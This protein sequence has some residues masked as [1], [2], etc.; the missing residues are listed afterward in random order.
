MEAALSF[1]YASYRLTTSSLDLLLSGD[2]SGLA[3]CATA[4]AVD[5]PVA[6]LLW[7]ARFLER[8]A[9]PFAVHC[10][11][12]T[13]RVLHALSALGASASALA[14]ANSR[15]KLCDGGAGSLRPCMP[16]SSSAARQQG[17]STLSTF[18]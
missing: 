14:C 12:A 18:S 5:S 15:G 7:S 3:I 9:P 11:N 2:G 10:N 1:V 6:C 17:L 13:H 16:S 4:D 8:W